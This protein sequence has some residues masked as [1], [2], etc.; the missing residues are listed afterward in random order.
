VKR[1]EWMAKTL[2]SY[3]EY[4]ANEIKTAGT[5]EGYVVQDLNLSE[6]AKGMC[7]PNCLIMP[8]KRGI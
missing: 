1:E 6:F 7:G 3:G 2:S 4:C 5:V 8:I